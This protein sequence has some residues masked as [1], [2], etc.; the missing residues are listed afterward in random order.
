MPARAL[1]S[2]SRPSTSLRSITVANSERCVTSRL[3]PSMTRSRI[4]GRVAAAQPPVDVHD[5]ALLGPDLGPDQD[6]VLAHGLAGHELQVV[7]ERAAGAAHVLIEA[8]RQA[9]HHDLA[10]QLLVA[11]LLLLAQALPVATEHE[12]AEQRRRRSWT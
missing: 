11:D 9:A 4:T 8:P 7:V 5:V 10:E 6:V 2:A 1:S 12:A 3:A